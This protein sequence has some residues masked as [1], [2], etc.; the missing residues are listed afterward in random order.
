MLHKGQETVTSTRQIMDNK[1][2]TVQQAFKGQGDHGS[3]LKQ[4][5][6]KDSQSLSQTCQEGQV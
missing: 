1:T 5:S 4:A 6:V 2:Q 3:A